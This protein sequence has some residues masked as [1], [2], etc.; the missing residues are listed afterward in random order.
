M[1]D[2]AFNL[3]GAAV[4]IFMHSGKVQERTGNRGYRLV[5]TAETY[6]VTDGY[7]SI[8]ANHQQ[9]IKI[10]FE[11]LDA[12]WVLEDVR[13]ATHAARVANH[14]ALRTVLSG[15]VRERRGEELEGLL[16]QRQ[17]PVAYVRDLGQILQHPH[18]EQR[19]TL[20]DAE[21]PGTDRRIRIAGPGFRLASG[22]LQ[23]GAVPALGEHS[24]EILGALG[25]SAEEISELHA[26][27]AL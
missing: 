27:G 10:L 6:Q 21:V 16:A 25:Y 3:D 12:D 22:R 20:I 5:A 2:S 1:L 19:G 17:V 14:E 4:P 18:V 26:S 23:A 9:Q 7:L 15:L 24:D 11:I 13:F 8:G